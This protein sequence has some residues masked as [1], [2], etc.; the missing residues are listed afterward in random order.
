M[1]TRF[2][3]LA[4]AAAVTVA[5][6]RPWSLGTDPAL[7]FSAR[8]L[9]LSTRPTVPSQPPP[10]VDIDR[11]SVTVTGRFVAA[12]VANP[13]TGSVDAEGERITLVVAFRPD[14][15]CADL[16][17]PFEYRARI[18]ELP[19]GVYTLVVW[20]QGSLGVDGVV[21][22]RRVALPSVRRTPTRIVDG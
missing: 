16:P 1:R 11:G 6:D 10:T 3:V 12:C 19:D 7:A 5:C 13:P 17:Q 9:D 21:L 20:Y 14:G 15:A 18:H 22:E 2:A 4:L 8:R